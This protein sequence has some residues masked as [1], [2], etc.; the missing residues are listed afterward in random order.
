MIMVGLSFVA[1]CCGFFINFFFFCFLGCEAIARCDSPNVWQ[2]KITDSEVIVFNVIV[3][4]L[5]V[6]K[7]VQPENVSNCLSF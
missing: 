5:W 1:I 4:L 6:Y 7:T 2:A 3:P